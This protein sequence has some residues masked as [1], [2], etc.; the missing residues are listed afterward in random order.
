MFLIPV[1]Y[2][3]SI[4]HVI[5]AFVYVTALNDK[6]SGHTLLWSTIFILVPFLSV[7]AFKVFH[8]ETK[9]VRSR[10]VTHYRNWWHS[11]RSWT[12]S[13][14]T[15]HTHEAVC[16]I[17]KT[18]SIFWSREISIT[19]IMCE[20]L[21]RVFLSVLPTLES[22]SRFFYCLW[23]Y[24]ARYTL[25]ARQWIR[26]NPLKTDGSTADN[27]MIVIFFLWDPDNL[28]EC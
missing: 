22:C 5:V 14:Q 8:K 27:M 12:L 16:T 28:Y 24:D 18:G 20:V 17:D 9:K 23:F 26:F 21:E 25:V 19:F 13:I 3:L 7:V 11:S 15:I 4:V 2:T 10:K 6:K 1:I